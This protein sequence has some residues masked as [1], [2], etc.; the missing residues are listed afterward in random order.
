M[1]PRL[2]ARA[3]RGT[4]YLTPI[5][6]GVLLFGCG[7][8]DEPSE[9]VNTAGQ[10]PTGGAGGA[11]PD[12][13]DGGTVNGGAPEGNAGE[14]P[15][16]GTPPVAG[17]GAGGEQ[18]PMAGAG[19]TGGVADG[20]GGAGGEDPVG[21]AGG[22]MGENPY[23][24]D[25][26]FCAE[27]LDY[28]AEHYQGFLQRY[29]NPSQIPRSVAGGSPRIVG[30]GDW[31]SGFP[32][33]SLWYLYEHT[34]DD[35]FRQAA[36]AW[37]Q[38]LYGERNRTGDHDIGFIIGSSYGNGLR[39]TGNTD[40]EAVLE[41]A[42]GSLTTRFNSN[43][44]AIRSWDF[45][46]WQYPVIIDNMMNLELLWRAT[47]LS[48]NASFADV[49]VSHANKTM[50]NHF[51]PDGSSYHV[52][53]YNSSNGSVI[54]KQTNQGLN[55]ESA[56][57]RGQAWGLYG[58]TMSYRETQDEA[59]LNHA[60]KIA[61]FYTQSDRMPDDKVPYFDFDAPILDNV[62][63]HRDSSAGAIATSA[64]LELAGYVPEE[65]SQRY[66]AF[67]MAALRSLSSSDYRAD[68]G[69][70]GDFLL[71]HAVGNYPIN[72]EIDVAINYAEYYYLEALVRCS[73]L[74]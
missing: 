48:G 25:V 20:G 26:A 15:T 58:Y 45:G 34:D 63:D 16:G 18:P 74:E 43:V 46:T 56:W 70:N 38:A 47:E 29:T 13:G 7:D 12:G 73:Q 52:L 71:M 53:D 22:G 32:A 49:A 51:R 72:D 57:A 60:I 4:R 9:P 55:D 19:G 1:N 28:A 5:L 66:M 17:G 36:E 35:A 69:S 64:L 11:A 41:T 59:Y 30:A 42:A 65:A 24:D 6:S 2:D 31:T 23:A 37:T 39:L 54:S 50:A 33:G 21:G 40:Y 61:D 44:G 67:A 10:P 62:P 68:H 3:W 14:S 27:Q 8:T